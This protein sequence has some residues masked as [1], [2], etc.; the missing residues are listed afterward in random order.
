MKSMSAPSADPA[1]PVLARLFTVGLTAI[2]AAFG[3]DDRAGRGWGPDDR[4]NELRLRAHKV[5]RHPTVE[6]RSGERHVAVVVYARRPDAEAEVYRALAA[7]G[8]TGGSGVRVPRLLAR[9][10]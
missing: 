3:G 6:V 2:T 5:G 10:P 8:L 1:L 9:H 4:R 7:E